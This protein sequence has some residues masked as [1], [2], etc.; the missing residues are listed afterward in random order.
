MVWRFWREIEYLMQCCQ[1]V[2]EISGC[3]TAC[4]AL[5]KANISTSQFFQKLCS[6]GGTFLEFLMLKLNTV[7]VCLKLCIES[8]KEG[9]KEVMYLYIRN[10]MVKESHVIILN[11]FHYRYHEMITLYTHFHCGK[12]VHGI[13]TVRR[14]V[15]TDASILVL[16][17]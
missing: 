12:N 14:K 3:C 8:F 2:E 4:C 11:N 7:P 6:P 15:H 5:S 10:K 16:P 1:K 13:L 17:T 9:L